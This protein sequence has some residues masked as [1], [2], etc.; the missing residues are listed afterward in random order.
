MSINGI[1][2]PFSHFAYWEFEILRRALKHSRSWLLEIPPK[3]YLVVVS[4]L[5]IVQVK[6]K[7]NIMIKKTIWNGFRYGLWLT[8]V[9]AQH[10]EQVVIML[11]RE[12]KKGLNY[13]PLFPFSVNVKLWSLVIC[14]ILRVV[15]NDQ[16]KYWSSTIDAGLFHHLCFC[17]SFWKNGQQPHCFRIFHSLYEYGIVDVSQ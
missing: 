11:K 7:L 2:D 6:R 5:G 3:L 1:L 9:L 10:F 4:C 17:S 8:R 15:I 14:Y 16:K 12:K 13:Q